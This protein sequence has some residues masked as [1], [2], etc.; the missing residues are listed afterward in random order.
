MDLTGKRLIYVNHSKIENICKGNTMNMYYNKS[1]N[2]RILWQ[3]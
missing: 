2:G 1:V 3:L